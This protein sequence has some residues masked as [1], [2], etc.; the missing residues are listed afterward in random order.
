MAQRTFNWKMVQDCRRENVGIFWSFLLKY[1][2]FKSKKQI[3]N[4][5][6]INL[7]HEFGLDKNMGG[8]AQDKFCRKVVFIVVTPP[9]Q[10]NRNMTQKWRLLNHDYLYLTKVKNICNLFMYIFKKCFFFYWLTSRDGSTVQLEQ[11]CIAHRSITKH[12]S[13]MSDHRDCIIANI[14]NLCMAYEFATRDVFNVFFILLSI[15]RF[16]RHSWQMQ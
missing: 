8:G 12:L 1:L 10:E 13:K 3:P 16:L 7:I 4:E 15:L 14:H 9:T 2:K 6:S 5:D 11:L